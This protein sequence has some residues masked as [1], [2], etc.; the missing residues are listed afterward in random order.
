MN[1]ISINFWPSKLCSCCGS[2][3]E[4]LKLCDRIYK[5]ECGN[6]MDRDLN[7]A[8]N[9]KN[10]SPKQKT[11]VRYTGSNAGV[12]ESKLNRDERFIDSKDSRCSSMKPESNKE[13]T[14]RFL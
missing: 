10:Y 11:T 2:L 1:L 3:K 5:C 13:S 8:I 9:I 6:C 14:C 4:D 7:A 12:C